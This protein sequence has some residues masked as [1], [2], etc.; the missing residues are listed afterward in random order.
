[1][2]TKPGR[3]KHTPPT[4][5]PTV[6]RSRHAQKIASWLDAGPG[7][8]FV[9]AMPSSNSGS[10]NQARSRTHSARSIA[11]CVG[12]PPNPV[13]P[14]RNHSCAIVASG[15]RVSGGSLTGSANGS[16]G[17]ISTAIATGRTWPARISA[18]S[19]SA[20]CTTRSISVA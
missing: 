1:M 12:G 8:R 6:P 4:S 2:I 5:A 10:D 13:T 15:T 14:M 3:M 11:M 18:A 20:V 9:A 7:S 16:V 17:Q 19:S